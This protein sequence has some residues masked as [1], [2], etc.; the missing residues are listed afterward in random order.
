MVVER[1][2]HEAHL[3]IRRYVYSRRGGVYPELLHLA[4]IQLLVADMARECPPS[5]AD[6]VPTSRAGRGEHA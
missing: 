4:G 2:R 3:A 1:P 6:E 5:H